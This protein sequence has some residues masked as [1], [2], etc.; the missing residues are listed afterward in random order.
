MDIQPFNGPLA[1]SLIA[2]LGFFDQLF[3]TSNL[4]G[5]IAGNIA[6]LMVLAFGRYKGVDLYKN[7]LR[8]LLSVNY[9][10]S[11]LWGYKIVYISM[12]L[13]ERDAAEINICNAL[14]EK[15]QKYDIKLKYVPLNNP[16]KLLYY[17]LNSF[18]CADLILFIT[19]VSRLSRDDNKRVAIQKRIE[20][21]TENGGLLL[22][23]HDI[24]YRRTQN[25]IL[26][27]LLGCKSMFFVI[28]DNP[29]IPYELCSENYPDLPASFTLKDNEY[30][31]AEWAGDVEILYVHAEQKENG[32][33]IALITKRPCGDHGVAYWFNSGDK[34]QNGEPLSLTQPDD[35]LIEI[36]HQLITRHLRYEKCSQAHSYKR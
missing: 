28:P 34:Q 35:H 27:D 24:I 9:C 32:P 21:Y 1:Q 8:L 31:V 17:P 3:Q 15:A 30:L 13:N 19:D 12:D 7:L 4:P 26:K 22:A 16:E 10:F 14:L 25:D 6:T 33:P 36:W 2:V 11:R 20:H 18:F 23:G 29:H 5:A